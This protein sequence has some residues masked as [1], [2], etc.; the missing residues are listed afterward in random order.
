MNQMYQ[1]LNQN[2]YVAQIN[3]L[4]QSNPK[5]NQVMNLVRNG[6]NPKQLFL[7]MARERGVDPQ[8]FLAQLTK[9]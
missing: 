8:S 6:G 3:S 4:L 7:Q 5:L 2:N 1:E 9:M